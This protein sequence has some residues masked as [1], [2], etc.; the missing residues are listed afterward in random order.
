MQIP[1][2]LFY[3][4]SY[5]EGF[6]GLGIYTAVLEIE[7][8]DTKLVYFHNNAILNYIMYNVNMKGK[9][10]HDSFNYSKNI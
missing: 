5:S 4:A 7:L 6:I 9:D 3:N 8:H 10:K 1:N 2:K